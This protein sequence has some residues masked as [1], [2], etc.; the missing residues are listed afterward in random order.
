MVIMLRALRD[1][2]K[3]HQPEVCGEAPDWIVNH[4]A[5]AIDAFLEKYADEIPIEDARR[6]LIGGIR[7]VADNGSHEC[8]A[9]GESISRV[10]HSISP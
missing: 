10:L 6:L 2:L 3:A 4:V 9:L 7:F 8:D 1:N 5:E